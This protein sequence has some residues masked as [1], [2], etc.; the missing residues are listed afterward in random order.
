MAY[1]LDFGFGSIER[2]PRV[3]QARF[4]LVGGK[5]SPSVGFPGKNGTFQLHGMDG[6]GESEKLLEMAPKGM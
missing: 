2:L 4:E 3:E 1:L 5:S 6:T